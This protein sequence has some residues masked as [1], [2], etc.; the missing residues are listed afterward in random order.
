VAGRHEGRTQLL[1]PRRERDSGLAEEV[2]LLT[3]LLVERAV[4]AVVE[5]VR[6]KLAGWHTRAERNPVGRARQA[7]PLA[8]H[9]VA[10]VHGP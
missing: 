7:G 1:A 10:G 2:R 9:R 6:Q 5:A 4:N 8:V 3:E